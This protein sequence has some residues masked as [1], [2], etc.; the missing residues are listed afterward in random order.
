MFAGHWQFLILVAI[1]AFLFGPTVVK[2]L[3]RLAGG[4]GGTPG[5]SRGPSG[6]R[7]VAR[8]HA[9][10]PHCGAENPRGARFCCACGKPIDFVDV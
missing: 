6:S 4:A 3:R 8:D 7:R 1:V 2:L 9:H 5:A 10:C